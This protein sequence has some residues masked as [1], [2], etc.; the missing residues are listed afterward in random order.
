MISVCIITKNECSHLN[1]CM[2]RVSH[3]PV[4]IIVVDTGS[5]DDSKKIATKYTNNVFDFEW[6]DDFAAA[7]NYAISKATQEYI[8]ML[9]TDEFIDDFDYEKVIELIKQS[10]NSMG[11]IHIKNLF[12]SNGNNMSSNEQILRLF[13]KKL[14]HYAGAIHEQIVPINNTST[15]A[16][17]FSAPIYVTHVGYNGGTELRNAKASRN[18]SILFN[19]LEQ[20]PNDSYLLYQIGKSYF[21]IQDYNKAITYFEKALEQPLDTRLSYVQ[22]MVTTFGY[23]LIYT[24]QYQKALMLEGVYDDFCHN[25]DYLFVLGL[26]YMHNAR[27]E[28]AINSF[29]LATHLPTCDVDG[30]NSYLAHYNIGVIFECLGDT[31]SASTYYQKCGDYSPALE[32]LKRC[33]K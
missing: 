1:I 31:T 29:T 25:A 20:Q 9:D 18:L 21:F 10:P 22:G 4:E 11:I 33:N 6:C 3:Y 32:G 17:P 26:I 27:F 13:P 7:R 19:E 15:P 12:Q 28:D 16:T 8:L 24:N 14:Y 30:V 5:S 23:C 2:E